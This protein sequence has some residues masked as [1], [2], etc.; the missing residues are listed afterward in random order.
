MRKSTRQAADGEEA[1]PTAV[2]PPEG[3]DVEPESVGNA[4]GTLKARQAR[5]VA[6]AAEAKSGAAQAPSSV[7]SKK[8]LRWGGLRRYLRIDSNANSSSKSL[9]IVCLSSPAPHFS[10]AEQCEQ[11]ERRNRRY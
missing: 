10:P 2:S 1:L 8:P 6:A 5:A 9:D 4:E 3:P 7:P 11:V